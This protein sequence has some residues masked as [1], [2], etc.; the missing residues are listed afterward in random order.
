MVHIAFAIDP[1][2]KI[3]FQMLCV[4]HGDKMSVVLRSAVE[5]YI[6]SKKTHIVKS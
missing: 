1:K 6:A 4:K 3:E 2:S 5:N